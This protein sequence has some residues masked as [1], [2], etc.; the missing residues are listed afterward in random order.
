[1]KNTPLMENREKLQKVMMSTFQDEVQTLNS[2]LQSMLIDD[3]ITAFY[4]RLDVMK[5]IQ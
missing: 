3:M 5:K 4:N 2:E 1:M